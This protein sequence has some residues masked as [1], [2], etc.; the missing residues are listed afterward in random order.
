MSLSDLASLGSFV[1]G[2]AILFSFVFLALQLRQANVNQRAL[3]QS[4]RAS[5]VIDTVYRNIEPHLRQVI[6]RGARGDTTMPPEEVQAFLQAAYAAFLNFEDTYLQNRAGTI[7]PSAWRASSGRLEI[8]L[9][10]PGWRVAWKKR[11]ALL[12]SDFAQAVDQIVAK[13]R[14]SAWEE[15]TASW[16]SDVSEEKRLVAN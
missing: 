10:S 9:A 14:L 16:A 12:E 7:H 2:V 8:I 6:L 11:R 5:R 3:I 4:A 15:P 13:A 1:S